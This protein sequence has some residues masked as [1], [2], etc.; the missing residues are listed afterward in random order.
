M[1]LVKKNGKWYVY[2]EDRKKKL[3]GPYDTK[4]EALKRLRQ[5]EYF[6]RQKESFCAVEGLEF[7]ENESGELFVKGLIATT[8]I[9]SYGDKIAKETL[10]KWAKEINDGIPRANKASYHHKRKETVLGRGANAEVVKLPDGEYGLYVETHVNRASDEYDTLKY[11]VENGFIDGYSVEFYVPEG[12]AQKQKVGDKEV[13]VLGPEAELHGYGF[14]SRP[15]NENCIIASYSLKEVLNE[16]EG[17]T[18]MTQEKKEEPDKEPEKVEEPEKKQPEQEPK[19]EPKDKK[20]EEPKKDEEKSEEEEEKKEEEEQEL[21]KEDKEMKE[22]MLNIKER[23]EK[24]EV[25][26]KVLK[27]EPKKSDT[28]AP[29][30]EVKE[31]AEALENKELS[32]SEKF[33]RA[34]RAADVLGLK[35]TGR[36]EQ[37]EFSYF[38]TNGTKLEFKGLGID[39]N[40]TSYT[41]S[42]AELSDIYDPVI[43][44]ALNHSLVTW[45]ILE[46][47]D[48]SNKGNNLV[49]F[50]LRTGANTSASFYSGNAVSTGTVTR[51]KYQTKFKK[52]QVGVEVDGDMIAAAKGGNVSDVFAQELE[53]SVND[54]LDVVN[55]ALFGTKGAETDTEIIGFEYIADSASYTTLYG[56]SRT[57]ANK[58]APDSA[59]DT[60]ID[61]SSAIVSMD[62]LRKAIE[63]AVVEGANKRNLVFITSPTQGRMMRNK[64]D[65]LRRLNG[66]TDTQFGFS[67]DLFIDGVPVFEDKD[68][69][70]DDIFLIDR[71][72]HRIAIWVPPTV[73]KLSKDG[74]YEGAFVKMYLA[75]YNRAP[76]RL[77]QI[78]SN[79]TSV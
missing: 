69:N 63:Q 38:S 27:E 3:G 34:G 6:K 22:L 26:E 42:A 13:R 49:Q 33:K 37:K 74:D 52:V 77:V 10:D 9:D 7:K 29:K 58:L 44:D 14:A 65:D 45:N 48:Y 66:P 31:F 24:M 53:D 60:Y 4:K 18:T 19:Q 30:L 21:K 73:E 47:D 59:G 57:A 78:H 51:E 61:G 67:T 46:K 41:Q 55:A 16:N 54:M 35:S 12:A 40:S 70:S 2:S 62:N 8:H 79:A 5:I 56:Q 17:E 23:L 20:E 76:R 36:A 68:C 75:T 71:E 43:Y 28:P 64:F 50:T 39:T 11:E 15:V 72:T 25:K 32:V 1:V